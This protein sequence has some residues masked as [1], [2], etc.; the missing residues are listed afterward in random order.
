MRARVDSD[1]GA[2]GASKLGPRPILGRGGKEINGPNSLTGEI[3]RYEKKT[4]IEKGERGE[5]G[6]DGSAR[7]TRATQTDG[8]PP[9][10]FSPLAPSYHPP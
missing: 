8:L 7:D 9:P 4:K 1:A 5:D 10:P 3:K 6:E 2:K